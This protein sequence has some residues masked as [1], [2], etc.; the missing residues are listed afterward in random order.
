MND[1]QRGPLAALAQVAPRHGHAW[2]VG[3]AVRDRLLG[4]DTSDFDL[5]VSGDVT[6]LAVDLGR[7]TDG[8]AFML[9]EQFGAW[10]VRARDQ[11]WQ[12]DMTPLIGD[13]L[14]QDLRRR[15]LTINAIGEEQDG[16]V[17][18]AKLV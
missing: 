3:G 7:A 10:R 9:S 12:V 13:T 14:E 11:S 8:H 16:S 4:R 6:G 15:D 2:L 18:G 5:A 1:A 17:A